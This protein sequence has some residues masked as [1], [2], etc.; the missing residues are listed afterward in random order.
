MISSFDDTKI[1]EILARL[2]MLERR[3]NVME[4][5]IFSM[6]FAAIASTVD[7]VCDIKTKMQNIRNILY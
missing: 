1:E 6:D 3:I 5:G 7:D 4:D 2:D